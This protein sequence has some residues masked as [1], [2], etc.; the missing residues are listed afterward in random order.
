M[1]QY[2]QLVEQKKKIYQNIRRMNIELQAGRCIPNQIL[3]NW[4]WN[5]NVLYFLVLYSAC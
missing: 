3:Q 4:K 2:T 1:L 5:S